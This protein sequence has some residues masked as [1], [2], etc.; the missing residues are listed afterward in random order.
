MLEFQTAQDRLLIRKKINM[1]ITGTQ[2]VGKTFA[3]RALD[4]ATTL[5]M[6]CEAGTLS[7]EKSKDM[8]AWQGTTLTMKE[9][10]VRHGVH[11]WVLCRGIA[12]L[13]LGPDTQDPEGYY[14]AAWYNYYVN[15][16]AGGNPQLFN[17]FQ[18]LYVDSL[19]VVS[20]WAFDWACQ[21][22]ECISEKTK[23]LDKRGAYGLMGTELVT[24]ATQLQHQP[25]N[26][27][28]SCILE[29]D[30]DDFK[31]KFWQLQ[32]EGK[33][34]GRKIPGIFDLVMTLAWVDFGPQNG[35]K[36]RVFVTQEGNELGFPAKDRSGLL[37]AYE[38]PDLGAIIT[39]IQGFHNQ[40][41]Q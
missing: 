8:P 2:G 28:L 16:F 25:K 5:F 35:G 18:T 23:K 27:I 29:E 1:L 3:A 30:E 37:E 13:L 36:Q 38:R 34:A 26:M 21:Q 4:P 17:Q 20:R 7:L 40:Q 9:M 10:A 39:K 12:S 32:I 31:R 41:P 22:P 15:A 19:T 6:D 33:A 11:P 24:W 14:G